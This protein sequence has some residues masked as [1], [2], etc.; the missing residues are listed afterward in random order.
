MA[1]TMKLGP[2]S[3]GNGVSVREF[4][5]FSGFSD[6]KIYAAAEVLGLELKRI[7]RSDPLPARRL[8]RY[9]LDE[10]QQDALLKHM[11]KSPLNYKNKVGAG[12]TKGGAWGVGK[13]PAACLRCERDDRPHYATGLCKACYV[14]NHKKEKR[15]TMST[16]ITSFGSAA[17]FLSNFAPAVVE[18]EGRK[19]Y[20]VE[21]AYQAAKT[22][23]GR[24]ACGLMGSGLA[25]QVRTGTARRGAIWRGRAGRFGLEWSDARRRDPFDSGWAG[26]SGMSWVGLIG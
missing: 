24:A 9:M 15:K 3:R 25:R 14:S 21:H 11:L 6:T 10:D 1:R 23:N 8:R 20:S 5:R 16:P 2:F 19:Y 22:G 17:R 13:K 12:K 7:K 18:F 4:S 26:R